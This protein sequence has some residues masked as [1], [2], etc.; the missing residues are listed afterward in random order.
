MGAGVAVGRAGLGLA[1][2][3]EPL[4]PATRPGRLRF[5]PAAASAAVRGL[6]LLAP[7]LVILPE[8]QQRLWPSP[9]G[10]VAGAGFVVNGGI[11]IALRCGHRVSELVPSRG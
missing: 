1:P 4:A 2:P 7:H 9:A 8:A 11:A 3:L 10:S 6:R 5:D